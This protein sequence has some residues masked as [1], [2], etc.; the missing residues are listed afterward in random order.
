VGVSPDIKQHE[1]FSRKQCPTGIGFTAKGGK[2]FEG[3][4][5]QHA[6]PEAKLNFHFRDEHSVRTE[7]SSTPRVN[8]SSSAAF[9]YTLNFDINFY[10]KRNPSNYNPSNYVG[11]FSS[12]WKLNCYQ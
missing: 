2:I 4:T 8:C 12:H 5:V 11:P 3:K 7:C 10:R 1:R 9:L 6:A